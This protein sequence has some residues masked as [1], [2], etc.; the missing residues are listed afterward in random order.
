MLVI[1]FLR[2]SIVVLPWIVPNRSLEKQNK[3]KKINMR[4]IVYRIS[5][6]SLSV[7]CCQLSMHQW[8]LMQSVAVFFLLRTIHTW[9]K[10]VNRQPNEPNAN[11]IQLFSIISRVTI[12]T[13]TN[14]SEKTKNVNH[15]QTLRLV[16]MDEFGIGRDPCNSNGNLMTRKQLT[17]IGQI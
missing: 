8:W 3:T 15:L 13:P 5:N 11:G 12:I 17:S 14:K 2:S 9:M 10:L 6:L 1:K 4:I 7:S 16:S